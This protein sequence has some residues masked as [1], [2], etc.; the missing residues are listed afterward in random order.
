MLCSHYALSVL[1]ILHNESRQKMNSFT[2][3]LREASVCCFSLRLQKE[4]RETEQ[5]TIFKSNCL[6]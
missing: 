2:G 1:F 4:K 5:T 3:H 6:F